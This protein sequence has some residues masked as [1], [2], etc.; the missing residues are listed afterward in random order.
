M[1]RVVNVNIVVVVFISVALV[2]IVVVGVFVGVVG[3]GGFYIVGFVNVIV[4]G[5]IV[6][7]DYFFAKLSS[8]PVKFSP[9]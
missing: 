9:I 7:T 1:V 5:L 6:V 4:L 2:D 3:G 8:S